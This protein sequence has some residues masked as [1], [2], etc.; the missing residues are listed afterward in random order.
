L[1]I[2]IA[3][4]PTFQ[5]MIDICM[6]SLLPCNFF[7]VLFCVFGLDFDILVLSLKP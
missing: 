3:N 6:D 5:V 4:F 2:Q 1:V 7:Y